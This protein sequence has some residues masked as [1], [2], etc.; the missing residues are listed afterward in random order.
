MICAVFF[1][2]LEGARPRAPLEPPLAD[3][4]QRFE[5]TFPGNVETY[6]NVITTAVCDS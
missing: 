3:I 2:G 5:G 6:G 4:A 1:F